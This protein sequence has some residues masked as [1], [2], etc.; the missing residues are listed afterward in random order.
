MPKKKKRS[1]L[2]YTRIKSGKLYVVIPYRV[3]DVWKQKARLA[4]NQEDA[5]RV[6]QELRAEIGQHGASLV[7]AERMTFRELLAEYR[8]AHPQTPAWY[9]EPPAEFFGDRLVRSITYAD[10][11]QFRSARERVPKRFTLDERRTPA[12]INR[13]LEHLR[14]VLLYA[15]R[16]GWI[17]TNPFAAGPP[18]IL[19]AEE[20]RRTRVPTPAEE[21]ALLAVCVPP[22]RA[23]LRPLI[24]AT[25]DTGLRRSALLALTWARVDWQGRLLRIPKGNLYK[26]RPAVIGLTAR[27]YDELR[28]LWDASDRNGEGKVFGELGDF[29]KAYATACRLAG[30]RGLRFNDFRHGFATDLMEADVPQHLAMQLAGHTQA[31]T[32]A[33]YANVDDRLAL[34]AALALDRLHASRTTRSSLTAEI[35]EPTSDLLQ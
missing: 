9:H 15:M 21:E 25:R 35:D 10:L 6:M 13:E 32:H 33:I 7:A 23:H 34:Q 20:E 1:N 27:L 8:R 11:R 26:R 12:T 5:L 3:G 22:H 24:I 2:P 19:K 31:D 17:R 30:I 18:L 4:A 16:H 29:K 14:S 28:R